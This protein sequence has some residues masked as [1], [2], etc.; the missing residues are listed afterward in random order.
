MTSE[1]RQAYEREL[2][3]AAKRLG[4]PSH[5]N[6]EN[7]LLRHATDAIDALVTRCNPGNLS[8]LLQH[9]ATSLGLEIVE[10]HSDHDLKV[11]LE[12]IP[13][14]RE[15]AL[16]RVRLELDDKTDAVVLQRQNPEPWERRYLAVINCRSWH[17]HR[18]YFSKWH[19]F[20]HLLLE[21]RQLRLSFR[22][23]GVERKHPEEILVDKIAGELAFYPPFFAPILVDEIGDN[24]NLTFAAIDRIRQRIA[25]DASWHSTLVAAVRNSPRP[26]YAIRAQLGLKKSEEQQTRDLLS[27]VTDPPIAKLR[28]KEATANAA[29]E[30]LGIRVHLNMEVP[31]ESV[32]GRAFESPSTSP[33]SGREDLGLWRTS[34]GPI[35]GGPISVEAERRG[36]DLWCLLHLTPSTAG[37]GPRRQ[38]NSARDKG[39]KVQAPKP[40][41]GDD[42]G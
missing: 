13:P 3:A 5:G 26:V 2:R 7:A 39:T 30:A 42:Q 37:K 28:V 31:V 23:T 41:W 1:Q 12:R 14:T 35:G 33:Q 32:A 29:A 11:L 6:I 27:T 16:A 25:P 38:S 10:I 9:A 20:V 21:G 19:E 22:K 15:P 4:L 34:A 36:K 17:A 24:S 40:L 18:R 8:E